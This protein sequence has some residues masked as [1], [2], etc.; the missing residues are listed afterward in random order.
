ML[1]RI[2]TGIPGLDN[3]LEGGFVE[4]ST[5]L[6]AGGPGTGKTIFC[7]QFMREGLQKG[8]KCLYVTLEESPED[9]LNDC[10]RFGWNIDKYLS[11]GQLQIIFKDPLGLIDI[12]RM[13]DDVSNGKIKRVAIDSTS[14][15]GLHFNNPADVR[16]N[17]F[18]VL[19][20]IKHS[21]ATTMVTAESPEEGKTI[22]RFGV[23]EYVTD[24]VILLHYLGLGGSIYHS[25]QIR[26]MRRTNHGKDIYPM[27]ITSKGIVIKKS[28][29]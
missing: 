5:V 20:A 12:K 6:L 10:S 9:I 23:E 27:D 14:L 28:E 29:V 22:T 17:L 4:G 16:K 7:A 13:F 1:Q 3:L 25:L 19:Q 11:T 18:Q 26:K 24:G 21:G 8:E 2:T 15:L